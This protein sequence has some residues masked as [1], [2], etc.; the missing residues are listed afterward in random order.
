MAANPLRGE[1]ELNV[2][3]AT[4]KLALD[5]NAFC[6]IESLLKLRPLEIVQAFTDSPDGMAVPR[7]LLWGALQKNHEMTLWEAGELMA[8]AGLIETRNALSK[9]L[10]LMFGMAKEAE[11]KKPG[12]VRPK[13][14]PTTG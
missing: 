1:S 3:D 13:R 4:Y 2:G 7:A 9:A 10:A 6:S 14:T 11:G 5:V 8:E 12:K